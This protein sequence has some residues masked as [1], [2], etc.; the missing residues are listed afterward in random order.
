MIAAQAL[1]VFYFAFFLIVPPLLGRIA[2]QI[3]T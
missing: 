3:R 2:A 1:A